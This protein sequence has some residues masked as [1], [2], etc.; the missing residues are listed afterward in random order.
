M[1]RVL[2][3]AHQFASVYNRYAWIHFVPANVPEPLFELTFTD[4]YAVKLPLKKDIFDSLGVQ[5]I[6]AA[7]LA[8]SEQEVPGFRLLGEREDCRLFVRDGP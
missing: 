8:L 7:G 1:L 6:V 4:A 3:P 2:D 5:Y